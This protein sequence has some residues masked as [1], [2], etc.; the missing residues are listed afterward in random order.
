MELVSIIDE[1]ISFN[2]ETMRIVGTFNEPWFVAKDICKI[3]DIKDVSMA[4]NK[5]PED[6]K[7]MKII[8]TSG[9]NQN[10]V[11]INEYALYKIIMRSNKSIAQKFQTV[12]CKEILPSIR[13]K[14][15]YKI[16]SIIDKNRLLE[17]ENH[18]LKKKFI[19]PKK[20]VYDGNNV[21]YLMASE[22]SKKIGEYVIGKATNLN[23]R[24]DDYEHNKLHNFKVEYY[25]SFA[26]PKL[27]DIIEAVILTKLGK[28]RCKAGRDV[29]LLPEGKDITLFTD[30]FNECSKFFEDIDEDNVVYPKRTLNISSEKTKE[31]KKQYRL[32]NIE[33]VKQRNKDYYERNKDIINKLKKI[34]N[35]E[36]FAKVAA[37]R[38]KYYEE[39]KEEYIQNVLNYYYDNKE[40]ILEDRKAYYQK[41]KEDIL[42]KRQEYY[43]ENYKTKIAVKRSE[44]EKCECG[45]VICHAYMN[46]HKKTERHKTLMAKLDDSDSDDED[47]K[48]LCVCGAEILASNMPRHKNSLKHKKFLEK[49]S[50]SN[51]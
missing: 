29:F 26:S 31:R 47:D 28:Y 33:I 3:L 43:E 48:E 44:K 30:T 16:Q 49:Q 45:M 14:G 24:K 11:I 41:N 42:E 10:M 50:E 7:D 17:E 22:E 6:W 38:K 18:Q 5:L 36:N 23:S 1:S 12:V 37:R 35:K 34:Y 2:N 15:E 4:V 39:H 8:K 32:E 46:R 40:I 9:G 25:V 20:E 21:V 19:K 27:M 51:I 13:K